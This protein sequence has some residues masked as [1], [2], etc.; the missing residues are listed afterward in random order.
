[1]TKGK[2]QYIRTGERIGVV[3]RSPVVAPGRKGGR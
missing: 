2:K 1:M 3:D